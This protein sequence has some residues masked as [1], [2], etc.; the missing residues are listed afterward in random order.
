[1]SSEPLAALDSVFVTMDSANAPLHI[2]VLIE[3]EHRESTT[4]DPIA[5]FGEIRNHIEDRLGKAAVL[6]RRVLRVPF[7]LGPPLLID[8]PDFDI[9]F[10][11]V[12]RAVPSPGGPKE[13]EALIARVMARPLAPDRPLWEI[14]VIEGLA[15]GGHALLAKVHHA[16]ADGVSG[17]TVFAGLFD[18]G[19]ESGD[20]LPIEEL[21]VPPPLP[22]PME[23]LARSS[24]EL[25]RRPGA[26]L[27]ALGSG[28]ERLAGKVDEITGA[29]DVTEEEPPTGPTLL[30]APRTALS[31]TVS[32]ARNFE[33]FCLDLTDVKDLTSPIGGTVTDFA[34]AVVGGGL[35]RLLE[36]RGEEVDRDLVCFT[37]VNIRVPGTE[38]DLGNMISGKLDPL[39][40][41]I[42][43]PFERL[44]A[45]SE[46]SRDV[47]EAGERPADFINELAE[48]AGPA[49]ASFAGRLISA[50]DLFEHLPNVAN[51]IISSVPGPPVPLGCA[52]EQIVRAS[53]MGPLMFNQA[54]NIT[55]LGY[56]GTLEF[57][58]LACAKKV[59]DAAV[60]CEFLE[61][62]AAVL[63]SRNPTGPRAL[64]R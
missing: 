55:V 29:A 46:R 17:V 45:L 20:L 33:R 4:K 6:R 23:L 22:S 42:L 10:H 39:M 56:A 60:L 50:F 28:L 12:R 7:D 54:L 57:G 27:E 32:Y 15:N 35:R 1:M 26:I 3:L 43:D 21:D 51:V 36:E 47:R 8:D 59:P 16:L 31:G 18:L 11:V 30:D 5:R 52:G 58:I 40:V 41:D 48:A 14:S 38:G 9:D 13:L 61:Q 37:P 64:D 62:E 49:V 34:M 53:P 63:L 44:A 19:P 24:S 25:L 2:G